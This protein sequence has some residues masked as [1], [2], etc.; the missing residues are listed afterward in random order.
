MKGQTLQVRVVG[1]MS[2]DLPQPSDAATLIENWNVDTST[3]GLTSRV[4]YEKYRPSPSSAFAPFTSLK[5]IDSLY[6]AQ[7]L[8]GGARQHIL[9]ESGGVLYLYYESGQ[10]AQL[11]ALSDR[12][13]PTSTESASVYAQVG[14]RI[15]VTNGHDYPLVINPWPLPASTFVAGVA[16]QTVR[17]LG[18][19]GRPPQP[20]GLDVATLD[21]TTTIASAAQY[22]GNATSNWYPTN[23]FAINRPDLFGMG[24]ADA[25]DAKVTNNYRFK[26]SYINDTGSESPLSQDCLI[27]WQIP[28]GDV[29]FRYCPTLRIPIGPKGTRARRIYATVDDGL[30][31]FFVADVRN[32]VETLFHA[33]RRSNALGFAAPLE[34]DSSIMPAPRARVCAAFKDCLFLDGG[35]NESDTLFFSKPGFIDQFGSADYIR[36][37]SDGGAITGLYS[38][39]NNLIVTRENGLDVLTGSYPNFT[40]QTVTRQVSCRAPNTLAAVPGVGVMF[41]AQDGIY[42]LQGGLDGGSVFQV[43]EVGMPINQELG[44]LTPECSPRSVAQYSPVDRAYHIYFPVDGNDRPSLGAVYHVEKQ[45]WSLR[46]G[47]PVGSLAKNFN[48]DLIFGHHTGAEA[49]GQNPESGLFVLSGIR[50]MGG[51]VSEDVYVTNDPPTSIYESAWQDFGD[52]QVKKQVQYC[53]L[54]LMTTGSV[55]VKLSYY[56][57]FDDENV[58]GSDK[59]Y[60]AQPP[61][62]AKQPVFDSAII[63]TGILA[64][65]TPGSAKWQATRLVP[66]RIPV[67]VQSCSWF[68]FRLETTDDI[69]L[70]G[71]ELEFMARGTQVI[72]GKTA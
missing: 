6:I 40:A 4:G 9:F 14:D 49:G 53:T 61:D 12:T 59:S 30:D 39:Y 26:V 54:W 16:S 44:R 33:F 68:K 69:L 57:D 19:A 58:V 48:G 28:K 37:P 56:K 65:P 51:R 18:F 1:G 10:N 29:G 21:A 63:D 66:L 20:D 32:N 35:A 7:Q 47:F 25:T 15:V 34:S 62:Q 38:Y 52:A 70:I 31:F 45:G 27:V 43:T 3:N 13:V 46:T 42:A 64:S 5:R 22:S 24:N 55:N 17:P 2:Q 8:P 72:A 71:Y 11:I 36:L 67:A 41:L 60:L 23:G 50:A